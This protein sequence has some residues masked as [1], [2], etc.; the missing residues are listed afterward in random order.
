MSI[1][2]DHF[3]RT[4]QALERDE[5]SIQHA[6]DLDPEYYF[7]AALPALLFEILNS[8]HVSTV[9]LYRG[10][11]LEILFGGGL[12]SRLEGVHAW[13]KVLSRMREYAN[14]LAEAIQEYQLE[15]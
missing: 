7:Q 2:Y 8:A 13:K 1:L 3:L 9:S 12:V 15:K 14:D 4:F 6:D 11:Y 5:Y 10:A